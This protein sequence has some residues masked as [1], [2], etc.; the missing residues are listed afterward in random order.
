M[1][2]ALLYLCKT[3]AKGNIVA[4][5]GLKQHCWI[6]F[7]KGALLRDD[8]GILVKPGENSQSG[9]VIKFTSVQQIADMDAT[10]G[11]FVDQAIKAEKAGLKVDFRESR[12]LVLPQEFLEKLEQTPGLKAAFDALT[13]GRQRA[14]NLHFC[15]AK[16]SATRTARIDKH[17]PRILGGKG[18][19]DR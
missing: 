8:T 4:I 19:T 6:A 12:N 11:A 10:I 1:E 15:A 17:I 14:Y 16:Q 18:L 2:Q 5:A 9:R 7:F 13:P 3:F